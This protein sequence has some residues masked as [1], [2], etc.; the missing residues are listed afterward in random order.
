M[1][2]SV[3]LYRTN[4]RKYAAARAFDRSQLPIPHPPHCTIA[5]TSLPC[6]W[7]GW[8]LKATP[9]SVSGGISL[10]ISQRPSPQSLTACTSTGS[11]NSFPTGA[12]NLLKAI[13]KQTVA[14][15]LPLAPHRCLDISCAPSYQ[16]KPL[17]PPACDAHLLIRRIMQR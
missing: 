15:S 11:Y 1:R 6:Q 2:V 8:R 10:P 7:Q 4:E 3:I 12:P 13:H 14:L 5:G 16:W 9:P 17:W